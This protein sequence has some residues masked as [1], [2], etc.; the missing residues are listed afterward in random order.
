[1]MT[2][3]INKEEKMRL[4]NLEIT[5]EDVDNQDAIIDAIKEL[6]LIIEDN[7]DTVSKEVAIE[8][9]IG[10]RLGEPRE[11]LVVYSN[12]E[13]INNPYV[14]VLRKNENPGLV[15]E[16]SINSFADLA[17]EYVRK[18]VNKTIYVGFKRLP[19][20]AFLSMNEIKDAREMASDYDLG[21]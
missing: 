2:K 5:E 1:M 21:L 18:E 3:N 14:F 15:R 6:E 7:Y 12:P 10:S 16:T 8:F 17:D 20:Y 9:N 4:R 13:Y 19:Q 11:Y